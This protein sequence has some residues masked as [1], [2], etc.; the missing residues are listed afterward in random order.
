MDDLGIWAAQ[1]LPL[2]SKALRLLL[3]DQTIF[4]DVGARQ[5][6]DTGRIVVGRGIPENALEGGERLEIG[7]GMLIKSWPF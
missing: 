3:E 6:G 5:A 7:P 2:V 4:I 1:R